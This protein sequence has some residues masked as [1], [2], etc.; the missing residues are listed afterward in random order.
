MRSS[1]RKSQKKFQKNISF[2]DAFFV[3][4]PKNFTA[5]SGDFKNMCK[6]QKKWSFFD[7][8]WSSVTRTF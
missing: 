7:V 2:F 6:L 5:K 4:L 8:F 1:F 3:C